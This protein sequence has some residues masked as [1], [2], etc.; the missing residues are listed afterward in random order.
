MP[1]DIVRRIHRDN[2]G[3]ELQFFG[4]RVAHHENPHYQ[5]PVCAA[6][7]RRRSAAATLP[8]HDTN[9]PPIPTY[10]MHLA[11]TLQL[12]SR[13]CARPMAMWQDRVAMWC[14]SG[15]ADQ[16][17]TGQGVDAGAQIRPH[18]APLGRHR[19]HRV[20]RSHAEDNRAS[21]HAA[22]VD[23]CPSAAPYFRC[24]PALSKNYLPF[25]VLFADGF[26]VV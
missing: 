7:C 25:G 2:A 12:H 6:A 19:T 15:D 11:T 18:R 13:W 22:S 10:K 26:L 23:A 3:V 4:D 17:E 21:T 5:P 14:P 16:L 24:D 8:P 9:S 1:A 20:V